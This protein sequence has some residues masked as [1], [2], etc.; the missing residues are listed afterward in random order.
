[1]HLHR[2][3]PTEPR[4]A[5]PGSITGRLEDAL[6]QFGVG[7][8][9]FVGGAVTMGVL[10]MLAC[11]T[12]RPW[13]FPSLAPTTLLMFETP[14]RPQASPRN[15]LV[16]HGVGIAVGFGSLVAFGL[17]H[18]GPVTA[19]GTS[20]ARVAATALALGV[21]TL[22]LHVF[23]TPHPP[24]AATVLIISLGLLHTPGELAVMVAALLLMV[25]LAWG[26]NRLGGVRTTFTP[27][28]W[29]PDEQNRR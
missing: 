16:G 21:T 6:G 17:Q 15:A 28:P 23:G 26:L 18:S 5:D 7:I 1:M 14:M 4:N 3:P 29:P 20:P 22:L 12:G 27:H 8:A 10:G 2:H 13:L 24:A 19:V 25:M 11:T 9:G